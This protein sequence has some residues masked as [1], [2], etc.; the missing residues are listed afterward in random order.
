MASLDRHLH[1]HQLVLNEIITLNAATAK[2]LGI[3]D[4]AL[5]DCHFEVDC[6]F[7]DDEVSAEQVAGN[8]GEEW[9]YGSEVGS[10]EEEEEGDEIR[11]ETM[12]E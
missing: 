7:E 1:Q 9:S 5:F 2:A 6:H 10:M 8:S 3:Y 4:N 11:Y 12:S